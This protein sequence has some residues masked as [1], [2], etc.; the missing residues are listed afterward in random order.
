MRVST[1]LFFLALIPRLN[2]LWRGF[3]TPDEPVWAF[4]AWRFLQAVEAHRWADTFQIGHPGAIT[5]WVGA[6]GIW[7][8]RWRDATGTAAHLSWIDKVAWVAPDNSELFKHLAPLLPPA[9]LVMAVL[10]ALGV[11]GVYLLARR[12]TDRYV[13]LAGAALLALDPFVI[14]LSGLLHVDAP[15]MTFVFLGLLAWMVALVEL[16]RRVGEGTL[17]RR[18]VPS[19][20]GRGPFALFHW[21]VQR[22]SYY[23][24]AWG[25]ALRV[26]LPAWCAGIC[27]GLGM[28]SKSPSVFIVV[29]VGIATLC[30]LLFVPTTRRY[31][32]IALLAAAWTVGLAVS[33]PAFPA[34]WVDPLGVTRRVYGL[35]DRHLDMPHRVSFFRGVG[36]GDP[37][38]LF[39]PTV[40]LFRLTPVTLVGAVLSLVV[41][42]GGTEADRRRRALVISLWAF[43]V[44]FAAF[45]TI[46]AKKFD[47]YLLPVFPALDLL[48][49]VGWVEVVRRLYAIRR[50]HDCL[51]EKAMAVV[52]AVMWVV[53]GAVVLGGWPYYLDVYNPL[54]GGVGAALR[55]LPVGWGEGQ[56]Q[57]AA[58]LKRL[59]GA[60]R[61]VVAGASPVTLGPLCDC[62]VLILDE[63][64]RLLADHLLVT[65]LDRQ[66]YPERVATLIADSRLERVVRVGGR[67]LLWL[68][69]TDYR[70]EEEHLSRYGAPGDVVLCDAATPFARRAPPGTMQ[71]LADADEDTVVEQL[72]RWSA[73][74]T[75]LWYLAYTSASPITAKAIR[76]QLEA[77]AT[78]LD[79]V[80]MGYVTATLYILPDEPAFAVDEAQ[81]RRMTFGQLALVGGTT[82][83]EPVRA[84][85]GVR[86]RLRW[87]AISAPQSDYAP[88]VHVIDRAGNL[89]AA[90]RG[91]ELLVDSRYWPTS[92]WSSGD[93]AEGDYWVHFPPGL[94]PGRYWLAVGLADVRTGGWTPALDKAGKPAGMTP[95]V[96]SLE[97]FPATTPPVADALKMPNPLDVTWKGRLRLLGYDHPARGTVGQTIVVE[98]GWQARR[99]IADDLT[100]RLRLVAPDGRSLHVQEFPLSGYPTSRW[101]VGELIHELYDLRLPA[102]LAGGE[103]TLQL[104]VL[105][106]RGDSLGAVVSLGRVKVEVEERLF[107]LPRPPQHP[108]RVRLGDGISL[109][110]YDIEQAS[111]RPGGT[112]S[113]TLYWQCDEPVDDNY[114]VFV[115]LLDPEG[116]VQGQQDLAPM[117]GRAPTGGWVAGQVIVDRY[118]VPLAAHAPAG[119]YQ[120]EAGMYDPRTLARLPAWDA[121][122]HRLP[123]DRVLLAEVAVGGEER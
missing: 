49:A 74:H 89:R 58:Y 67:E 52:L 63:S 97:V 26:A 76:R 16:G 54:V 82:L 30:Y 70:A 20:K 40:L 3:I 38:M 12:L 123:N 28:L 121:E 25:R 62:Q 44:G 8:Q 48:A 43:T 122:G 41:L 60:S 88:F 59:P 68:Y 32:L 64:S 23:L 78:P 15:A 81:F 11:V 14:G 98:L 13:A 96:M 94:P 110:G 24:G 1:V 69:A 17:W 35:A 72:N 100:V 2:A 37:G 61:Q 42:W 77:H 7:W 104:E 19:I 47:R 116:Q 102:D 46:G 75:R 36:G 5:M 120:I 91:E 10:T 27:A 83:N 21:A 113:L 79:R 80:D 108:L 71:V 73:S 95:Q 18:G 99:P 112:V 105:D 51:P 117:G 57:I 85:D 66:I 50:P 107:K 6:L 115:H 93:W 56:E 84:D 33:L 119:R 31:R 109:L 90:G 45:I 53:Q 103:C 22:W 114:T 101:R 29:A 55:T 87:R 39:Y 9:R 4:R 118:A 86:L 65:A 34:M 92:A 111:V 106:G